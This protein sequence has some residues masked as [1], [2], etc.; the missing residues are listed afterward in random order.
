MA[1]AVASPRME[2][3]R[4]RETLDRP[5]SDVWRIVAAFGSLEHW[6]DGVQFCRVEGEGVGAVRTVVRGG[7]TV[8]ERLEELDAANFLLSYSILDPHSLP[9]RDVRSTIALR[10]LTSGKTEF[11]WRSEAAEFSGSPED[12]GARIE[13]FYA[14]SLEGLRHLLG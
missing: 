4:I 10:Q 8:R 1:L 9:A 13:G 3:A 12:L 7:N 5:I 2:Y 6:V 14:K 11:V